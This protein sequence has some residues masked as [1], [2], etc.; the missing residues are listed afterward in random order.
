MAKEEK[1][2]DEKVN[3]VTLSSE[4]VQ[5]VF[6]L[7]GEAV[8]ITVKKRGQKPDKLVITA[9]EWMQ[10]NKGMFNPENK[11]PEQ[12]KNKSRKTKAK[13]EEPAV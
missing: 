9:H 4:K 1:K 3:A 2:Q 8:Y 5:L 13:K 12:E 11:E 10:I 6:A 7:H